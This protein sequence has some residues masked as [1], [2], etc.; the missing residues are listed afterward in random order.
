[1]HQQIE[2]LQN[3]LQVKQNNEQTLITANQLLSSR[4][5]SLEARLQDKD[6]LIKQLK[7]D[8]KSTS[9][10]L[11]RTEKHVAVL[12]K[13]NYS[14]DEESGFSSGYDA[15]STEHDTISDDTINQLNNFSTSSDIN[16]STK[17]QTVPNQ[18]VTPQ[19][20]NIPLQQQIPQ[21]EVIIEDVADA[22]LENTKDY[23]EKF[24][25][26]EE[27]FATDNILDIN[28]TVNE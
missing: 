16:K 8:L 13:Q 11:R 27:N 21:V 24:N 7:S 2:N 15:V 1:L 17:Q 6:E 3:Q 28:S 18:Q 5:E 14:G 19:Q 10:R 22:D 9:Q 4:V 20:Q 25:E 26:E 12:T 23:L